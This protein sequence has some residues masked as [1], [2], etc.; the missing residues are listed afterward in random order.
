M[1][2]RCEWQLPLLPKLVCKFH[3][4]SRVILAPLSMLWLRLEGS[5]GR[6]KL[7]STISCL[8]AYVVQ[9]W[10]GW[11]SMDRTNRAVLAVC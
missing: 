10:A 2:P 1:R 7:A 4:S 9:G 5:P 8:T 11:S 3:W 6:G